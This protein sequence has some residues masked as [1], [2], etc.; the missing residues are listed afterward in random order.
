MVTLSRPD[1]K[2]SQGWGGEVDRMK[3]VL[4]QTRQSEPP[5]AS[6]HPCPRAAPSCLLELPACAPRLNLQNASFLPSPRGFTAPR[7][8]QGVI[9]PDLLNSDTES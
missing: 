5:R 3:P 4:S 8:D 7:L 1:L 6:A 2:A 9:F